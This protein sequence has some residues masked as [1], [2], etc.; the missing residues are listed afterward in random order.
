MVV[1]EAAAV[2]LA[3]KKTL[4]I[5]TA[6]GKTGAAVGATAGATA[7]AAV[8]ATSGATAGATAG[9]ALGATAAKAKIIV[10]KSKVVTKTSTT[11]ISAK[12]VKL[13]YRYSSGPRLVYRLTT[14]KLGHL[15]LPVFGS[16]RLAFQWGK[17][18][19]YKIPKYVPW[20]VPITIGGL[21]FIWPAVNIS[22]ETKRAWSLLPGPDSVEAEAVSSM[23][24][25][26]KQDQR[27]KRGKSRR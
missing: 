10:A 25:K 5:T 19:M 22:E 16:V 7:G 12:T 4:A 17:T 23:Q 14:R 24:K 11:F 13:F 3:T 20:L 8:G 26:E 15:P 1:F 21:W 27:S 6:L 9:A 18:K 2:V